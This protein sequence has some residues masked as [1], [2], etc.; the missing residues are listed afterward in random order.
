MPNSNFSNLPKWIP[1]QLKRVG[2]TKEQLAHRVGVSRTTIYRYI[3]D[4]DRPSENTMLNMCRVLDIAFEEGLRQYTPKKNG[5]PFGKCTS[6][7]TEH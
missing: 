7:R 3:Y 5:R 2:L 4:M 1:R 6:Q